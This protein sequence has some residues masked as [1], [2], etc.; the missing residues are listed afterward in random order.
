MTRSKVRALLLAAGVLI[1][2][3]PG[4]ARAED[5]PGRTRRFELTAVYEALS[6]RAVYH[7]WK[8]FMAGFYSGP[9]TGLTYFFQL[10][11]FS[12]FEGEAMLGVAGAYKDWSPGFYT[13]TALAAG[14]RSGYLPSFRFD[15]DSNFKLGPKRNIVW[16]VG[17]TY[18]RFFDSHRTAILSTGVTAY[19]EGWILTYRVFGNRSDP[20][21]VLSAAHLLDAMAG[22]E[23]K[24]WTNLTISF[25]KQAYLATYLARPEEVNQSSLSVVLKHKH[26]FGEK[27]FG[28]LAEASYFTLKDGYDKLGLSAGFFKEF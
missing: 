1:A 12:R 9:K 2:A 7:S 22:A 25:G 10:G 5:P 19:L 15:H 16:T 11:G 17:F 4:P 21:R 28:L 18:I 3:F 24:R 8:N 6:P 20:G 23:G 27:G 14:T 26:W 13:Y